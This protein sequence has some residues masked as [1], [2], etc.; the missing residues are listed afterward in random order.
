MKIQFCG[1][2]TDVT[3]SCHLIETERH[4]ILLD[5][6]MFQGGKAAEAQNRQPFPFDPRD[7]DC[8]VISHA[9]ID[10]CGRLPLLVKRGFE[11]PI[12]ATDATA[13]LIDV[14]LRDSAHIH[15][16]EAEWQNRKNERAGVAKVKPLYTMDDAVDAIHLV[17]A[18][19][20]DQLFELNEEMKVVFNDAGHILGSAIVEL[21]VSEKKEG[22]TKLVFS[23][24]IGMAERPILKDP[25]RIKKADYLIMETTYGDRLHEPNPVSISRLLTIAA[26]TVKR[27][28]NVIIPSFAVGRTQ[29]LIFE[30]NKVYDGTGPVHEILKN[31][32]VYVDSPM[33]SEATEVFRKNA[34]IYDD[35]TREYIVRGDH[36]LDFKQ[37]TFTHS[38]EDS[39]A[40]NYDKRPKIIISA[41]GMC[42]AGRIRHHLKHNLWSKKNSIVFV[43]YQAEGTLGRRLIDGEKEVTLFGEVITVGAEIH[44]LEGFSGH[45]D[46]DQLFSWLSGFQLEPNAIFLVHGE[47]ESKEAFAR[48]VKENKGWECEV[49]SGFDEYELET[50]SV[51]AKAGKES[52]TEAIEEEFVSDEEIDRTRQRL[53]AIH[54]NLENILYNTHLAIGSDISVNRMTELKNEIAELEKSVMDIGATISKEDRYEELAAAAA[55]QYEDDE[56]EEAKEAGGSGDADR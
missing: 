44:S 12:Y 7:I 5:C 10:H 15:E 46:R 48:Y 39:I 42:D 11:G 13:D 4:K 1:A 19:R 40:I 51:L 8:V 21:F 34:Q 2:A 20:Y 25:K 33:A 32:P 45:A 28:G 16:Q 37:L 55:S 3:G 27:G 17:H 56:A 36:P 54:N 23:G 38:T 30:L 35:E 43:G 31:V 49:V 41:S 52:A 6:G 22:E 53:A 24:D 29:E 47:M 14:M 9:H 50:G 18:V 26:E